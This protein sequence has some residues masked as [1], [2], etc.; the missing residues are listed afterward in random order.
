MRDRPV[1]NYKVK[2]LRPELRIRNFLALWKEADPDIP[3]LIAAKTEYAKPAFVHSH[4]LE[5]DWPS[6]RRDAD[7]GGAPTESGQTARAQKVEFMSPIGRNLSSAYCGLEARD[8]TLGGH[9]RQPS[10]AYFHFY[11]ST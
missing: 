5:T 11:I 6:C 2:L 8:D 1:M 3:I 4:T 9:P 10:R 7:R